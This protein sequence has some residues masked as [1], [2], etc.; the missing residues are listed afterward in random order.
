MKDFEGAVIRAEEI[1]P[2]F[3][4]A[5]VSECGE[6]IYA[7]DC[8]ALGMGAGATEEY[9]AFCTEFLGRYAGIAVLDADALNALSVYGKEPLKRR[10]CRAVVTPHPKE[11]ARLAG[12]SVSAVLASPVEL[13]RAFSLEYGVTV[14]LKS[15][16][17]VIAEGERVAVNTT[18]S[19]ALAKGG[20]GDA[21][22]GFLAGTIARGLSSFDAARA[23]CYLFGRA[24]EIAAREMGEYA[25]D[26]TDVIARLPAAIMSL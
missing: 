8:A 21:L 18:G 24:G 11:F 14:V 22:A 20:S 19:P 10:R 23:A 1:K 12:T 16:F 17:T 6:A 7:A 2:L 13:A 4:A 25:P 26:A 3:P 15:H 5:I 9:Y